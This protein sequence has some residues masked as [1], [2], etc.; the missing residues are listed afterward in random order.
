MAWPT[1]ADLA[2][3]PLPGTDGPSD[4]RFTPDGSALTYIQADPGSLVAS[5]WRHDLG[6]G[7]RVL[8][9]GPLPEAESNETLS[10][11][12]QLHR[13]RRRTTALG[14][15]AYE[16][17]P[18]APRP[19]L[20]VPMSGRAL[21]AAG[22]AAVSGMAQPL[23]SV[24]DA[25]AA[26]GSPDGRWLAFARDGDV[27]LTRL[28]GTGDPARLTSDGADGIS[29]G[30][31]EY[32]AA[33]ELDRFD[34]MWWSWDG[35]HLAFA[36]VDERGVPLTAIAHLGEVDPSYE[37]HRYP[38]AG[39]PN[40]RVTLRIAGTSGGGFQEVPLPAVDD[41]GYLARVVAHPQGGWLVATMPRDQRTLHWSRLGED[42]SCQ[43]LWLEEADP[44]INLDD[45]TRALDDG[46]VVRTTERTGYRHLERRSADGS[47]VVQ[48]TGG[49]WVV[50]WLAHVDEKRR[51]AYVLGTRDSATERHLYAVPLDGES[52]TIE[53]RR[54]T[55]EPGWHDVAFS[56]DGSRW[57]DTWSDLETAPRVTV[58]ALDGDESPREIAAPSA[59]AT[60]LGVMPPQLMT[61]TTAD[62]RTALHAAFYRPAAPAADP[63]PCVV[64]VYGGPH[65]QYA[66][67]AWEAT[68]NPLRQY[69]ARAGVA[70][71]VVDN[72]GSANR[73]LAFERPLR[74][75]MG[76][77]EVEDQAAAVRQLGDRGWIDASRVGITG[78]SYGGYM[79]LRAMALEPH[80]FKVGVAVAPVT[81]QGGYDTAYTER[82]M[83]LPEGEAEA[84]AASSAVGVADR[85]RGSLL[86]V[87]GAIDENVHLR[88]STR[89]VETLQAAGRDVELVILPR[90][91]HR[92]RSPSGL[93][94]RDRRTVRHLLT[95]LGVRLPEDLPAD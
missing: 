55:V 94:T 53:P 60:A 38:Y 54:V 24:E 83:G 30:V 39:G 67:R 48:L 81:D 31:A 89:L 12:E 37:T 85:I 33:E 14:V 92:V 32:I 45:D 9:A 17:L 25:T 86:L 42:G 7:S 59:S 80:L 84:Y 69:L 21:V 28:D 82:Y 29:N 22:E 71:L 2:R 95:G 43:E 34:G 79:T 20:V 78:G 61:L 91:R 50:T 6:S 90:D 65:A 70:V 1:F 13:E 36:H 68:V 51:V 5:L 47:A 8:L 52:T 58:R 75:R 63:P 64:W 19:T 87:H 16:W 15:T 73:G 27:W 26:A 40:A 44:W 35:R 49:E 56:D 76:F 93:A 57:A 41:E 4:V 23:S 66:K 11:E 18:R 3:L 72:R 88:H 46:S 10:L 62:G 77:V 74:R